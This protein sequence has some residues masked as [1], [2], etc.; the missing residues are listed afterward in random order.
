M[1]M[2]TNTKSMEFNKN[3][4]KK[5]VYSNTIQPQETRKALNRQPNSTYRACGK[6]KQKNP[7]VSKRKEI[8]KTRE[9]INEEEMKETIAKINKAKSWF[10]Q[11]INKIDNLSKNLQD[12]QA[13]KGEKSNQQN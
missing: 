10:F 3:S 1:T 6:E 5:E 11:K 8:K 9:E 4:S 12:H 2:K 13:E 7:K